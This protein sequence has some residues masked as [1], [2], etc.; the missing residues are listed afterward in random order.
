MLYIPQAS[1][2]WKESGI[3]AVQEVTHKRYRA[4]RHQQVED[5]S[6]AERS[7]M[8]FPVHRASLFQFLKSKNSFFTYIVP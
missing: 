6:I 7:V 5:K 1:L 4:Q 3:N 8:V 2:Q